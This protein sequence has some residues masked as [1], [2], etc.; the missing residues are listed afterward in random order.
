MTFRQQTDGIPVID[1]DPDE[2][3]DYMVDFSADP[4]LGPW[5]QAGE[6]ITGHAVTVQYG[7][8]QPI[9]AVATD[10]TIT[11]WLSGGM[12]GTV[13]LVT[14]NITTNQGRVGDRSFRVNIIQR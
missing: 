4:P 5:L 6:V 1:K 11:V 9:P 2:Q 13:Y 3:L 8:S 14:V 12:I 7:I 10:T